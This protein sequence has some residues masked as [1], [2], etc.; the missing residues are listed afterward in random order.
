[1]LFLR[2]WKLF[3][4]IFYSPKISIKLGTWNKKGSDLLKDLLAKAGLPLNDCNQE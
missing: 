2:H 3:D 1:M 4:S